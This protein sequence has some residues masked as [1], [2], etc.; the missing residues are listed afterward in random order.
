MS[1]RVFFTSSANMGN[2]HR[3]VLQYIQND[4]WDAAH[5]LVQDYTD[6]LSCQIHGY[7][8]LIEGDL[9]NA[10][11]WYQRAG[12]TMPDN[13]QAEELMHLTAKLTDISN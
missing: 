11:Y 5:R 1:L 10:K 7:L 2:I 8:H 4:D 3:Q 6:Y 12:V 13:S 9:G